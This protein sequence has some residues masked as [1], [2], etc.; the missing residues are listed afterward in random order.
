M[1]DHETPPADAVNPA[2]AASP[3]DPDDPGFARAESALR[4]AL[5]EHAGDVD[6]PDATQSPT[7]PAPRRQWRWWAVAAIVV[8]TAL[9][10]ALIVQQVGRDT[11]LTPPEVG[12][13]LPEPEPGFQWVSSRD[14]AVQV[15]TEWGYR[16]APGPDWC[17]GTQDH[18]P[19]S[20]YYDSFTGDRVILSIGCPGPFPRNQDVMHLSMYDATTGAPELPEWHQTRRLGNVVV[21]V[22]VPSGTPDDEALAQQVLASATAFTIDQAGCAPNSPIEKWDWVSPTDSFDLGTIDQVSAISLCQYEK[23]QLPEAEAVPG[24]RLVVSRQLVDQDARQLLLALKQ[25]PIGGGPND[26]ENCSEDY[27]D[28]QAI[29]VRL[30]TQQGVRDAFAHVGNCRHNGIDDGTNVRTV[31]REWCLPLF[32]RPVQWTSMSGSVA[33]L[34]SPAD[35]VP[36]PTTTK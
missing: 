7:P 3:A 11:E 5:A 19:T 35:Q 24:P 23:S 25:A 18:Y 14:V 28:A 32:T 33:G 15:P 13:G 22:S 26:P 9:L 36:S 2:D 17:A 30:W 12:S 34:C 21:S 8:V 20:P 4:A 16:G 10:V 6:A 1:T 27:H 31:T 29:V